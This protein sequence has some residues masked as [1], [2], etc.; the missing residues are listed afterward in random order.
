MEPQQRR[1]PAGAL[2]LAG[3]FFPG[4]ALLSAP[5]PQAEDPSPT[6]PSSQAAT[7]AP[8]VP[9]T[10]GSTA[11]ATVTLVPPTLHAPPP[12]APTATPTAPSTGPTASPT[13]T[14]TA[15]LPGGTS[16]STPTATAT[17]P[18]ATPSPSVSAT[19]TPAG[20]TPAS[21]PSATASFV[22]TPSPV[23]AGT[24]L[25][26]EVAW[27]GTRASANDE[28]I[29]LHNRTGR[30][31][32]LEGWLLTDGGDIS[33]ALR[34]SIPA[35][36]YFLLERTDDSTVATR[37]ADL[38]YTGSL[39]NSGEA[40]TLFG[41]NGQ[42]VDR[43]NAAAGP[44]PAGEAMTRSSME[45][46]GREDRPSNWSTFEGVPMD[47]DAAGNLIAG[48]PRAP[49]STPGAAP[50]ATPTAPLRPSA[51]PT[52]VP[53]GRVLINEVAWAGTL[54][55][56]SDEWIELY[57][58][59]GGAISLEGWKL[60]DGN[61]IDIQLSGAIATEGYYLLERTDDNTV[62]SLPADLIYTGSL[63]NSGEPLELFDPAGGRISSANLAGGP[64]P[65]GDSAERRTMER[66]DGPQAWVTFAGPPTETDADGNGVRGTPGG[67]NSQLLY[68][69]TA[70]PTP[71][72]TGTKV[73][74]GTVLINEVA[75]SGTRASAS[76]EWIELFNLA[77]SPVQLE[78]W[79]LTDGGDVDIAL[80]GSIGGNDFYVLER[81]DDSTIADR[82]ADLLYS[83]TLSNRGE[84]LHLLA[85]DGRILDQANGDGGHWPA[86]D[87]EDYASMERVEGT[88]QSPR[89]KSFTGYFGMG[90]D[91]DGR[92]IRGTPGGPNSILF[93]TPTPTPVPGRLVINEVLIRPHYDWGGTGDVDTDDEFIELYNHGPA[94]VYVR[95]WMLD[96]IPDGGS[97]PA[98][99]PGVTIS[100]GGRA[101]FFKSET[102]ISLNDGGDQV[103]LL[104]PDG[105][106]IDQI[107]YLRVRAYNLSYGRLPD[108]SADL[109]Y[110]L[111]PTPG[112]ENV[113]FTEPA[114]GA[115]RKPGHVCQWGEMMT[116]RLPRLGRWP[117]QS[118]LLHHLGLALCQ[119]LGETER[120]RSRLPGSPDRDWFARC[121]LQGPR[122]ID[123]FPQQY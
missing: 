36:G 95:G 86:G 27:A 116:A 56:S 59:G 82:P 75:W 67:P 109:V 99:L 44:W 14:G 8:T 41:A 103:R 1:T 3:L 105:Q 111:W 104:T 113:L 80:S 68:P 50:S 31:V 20:G 52:R 25:I 91:A 60:T 2:L 43:A 38:I 117:H 97:R 12:T 66:I 70:S 71:T 4:S 48:S 7:A 85:P 35:D 76:D 26:N 34:G 84:S 89:W 18:S 9:P 72:A 58:P 90:R 69:P 122:S 93:P 13:P 23:A 61:D 108:G 96:D 54:A 17:I 119:P 101:A 15:T 87:A 73:P 55:S 6:I 83:G 33:I 19:S 74:A 64:W 28:W 102:G 22:P 10:A 11:T 77:S 24:V 42:T 79:R 112:E 30:G 51:T 78:G 65:A 123:G 110:G 16:S 98:T 29:E 57:N 94:P 120:D 107:E 5:V 100:P 106:Q 53:P 32:A 88:V 62:T 63:H 21:T 46:Q 47:E 49:N 40:L 121:K 115:G 45:R 92:R 37:S 39:R 81:S 118:R 114:E